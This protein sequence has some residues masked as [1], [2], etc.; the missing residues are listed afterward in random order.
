MLNIRLNNDELEII[1]KALEAY[2]SEVCKVSYEEQKLYDKIKEFLQ[3]EYNRYTK[4][5]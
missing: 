5:N 3:D 2:M 4:K 1:L